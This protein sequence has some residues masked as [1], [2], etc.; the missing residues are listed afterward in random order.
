MATATKY[1]KQSFEKSRSGEDEDLKKAHR[2]RIQKWRKEPTVKKL[3]KPTNP[4]RAKEL[5]YKAKK[6]IAVARVKER[7][8]SG[9]HPRPHAGRRPKKMG[10][11]KLKVAK[12]HQVQAEEKAEKK[13][14]NMVVINS[15]LAAQEGR[16]KF[17]EVIMADPQHPN[18]KNDSEMQWVK[19]KNQ[20]NRAQ[21]GKTSAGRKGRNK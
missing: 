3:E 17:Y 1:I 11:R 2:Q 19:G 16:Y 14:P 20:R 13:F 6:G 18:V 10:R 8:T 9:L 4:A 12:S 7:K 5:G 15:Y 21:R